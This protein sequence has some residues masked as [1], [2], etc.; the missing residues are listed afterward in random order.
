MWNTIKQLLF[1]NWKTTATGISIAVVWIAKTIFKIDIPDETALALT[2]FL[3][4]LGFMFT[5]DGNVS[6]DGK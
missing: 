6:G 4:S 3:V 1:K 5:K 2:A